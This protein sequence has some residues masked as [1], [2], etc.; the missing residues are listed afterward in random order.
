MKCKICTKDF[1][2][3]VCSNKN[4][5]QEYVECGICHDLFTSYEVYEYRG[6]YACECHIDEMEH[7][8]ESERLFIM[9]EENNKTKCFKNI[10]IISDDA[11]GDRNRKLLKSKIETSSKESFRLKNYERPKQ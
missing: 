6:S 7:N 2:G 9:Q 5:R 1:L 11:V 10:D 4:C 8:R 3:M